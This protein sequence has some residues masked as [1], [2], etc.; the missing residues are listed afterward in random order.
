[1]KSKLYSVFI[2]MVTLTLLGLNPLFSAEKE[3]ASPLSEL[4]F[5]VGLSSALSHTTIT[6][7]DNNIKNAL[8]CNYLALQVDY[9]VN[10]Y[11]TLGAI[12]GY[13]TNELADP[14]DFTHLPLS[15][16]VQEQT[17]KSMMFGLRAKSDFYS[18][19]DYSL[20]AYGEWLFFKRF[21]KEL[22]F[23]PPVPDNTATVN[24]D[25]NQLALELRAQYDG[26][27]N[28]TIF[29]GPRLNL[30]N[31][32]MIV[33]ETIGSV[34]GEEKLKFKQKH[35]LGLIGGIYYELNDHFDLS[36]SVTLLCQT[37][38]SVSLFYIF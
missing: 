29:A 8:K 11:L 28:F 13:N 38:L 22:L 23:Q 3:K 21:E 27:T 15:L 2:V 7:G 12:V 32:S 36:A 14:V 19:K 34:I 5:T 9:D 10:D 35:A 33:N 20:A 1:M 26:F 30:V 4:D 25:F 31:G 18:W 17:F 6:V 37:S 16:R 24:N